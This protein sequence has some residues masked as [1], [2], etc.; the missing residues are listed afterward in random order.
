MEI[1][2]K[3][4]EAFDRGEKFNRYKRWNPTLQEYLLIAQDRPQ[5]EHYRRLPDD[6][7][8]ERRHSG[9]KARLTIRS[10]RCRLELADVYDRVRFEAK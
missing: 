3:A 1:L 10:I 9:L 4:T 5:I 2:S 8:A 6:T 7:W